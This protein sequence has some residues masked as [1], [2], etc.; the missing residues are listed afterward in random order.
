MTRRHPL[1]ACLMAVI[2]IGAILFIVFSAGGGSGPD[3]AA[4][5]AAMQKQFAYGM[6]HPDGPVG[7]RPSECKDVSKADL[8]RFASE[9][10]ESYLSGG[11]S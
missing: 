1:I 4:C 9:I 3:L 2:S 6:A 11:G 7:A 8:Q 10:M 5:K